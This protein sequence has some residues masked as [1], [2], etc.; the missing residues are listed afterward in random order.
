[1]TEN[2][3]RQS[4]ARLATLLVVRVLSVLS[5]L[6]FAYGA[7]WMFTSDGLEAPNVIA[8]LGLLGITLT[9]IAAARLQGN[10]FAGWWFAIAA[11][12][13]PLLLLSLPVNSGPACPSDHPPLSPAYHCATPPPRELFVAS[14][15]GS[16]VAVA[17]ALRALDR[18]FDSARLGPSESTQ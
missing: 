11:V 8:W 12:S 9:S 7:T 4:P 16:L 2:R 5:A 15:I 3:K 6:L 18:W 13:M 14:L 17:G 10:T 1:M